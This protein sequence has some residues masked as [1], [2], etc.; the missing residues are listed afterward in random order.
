MALADSTIS[1]EILLEK[2]FLYASRN[3]AEFPGLK[4]SAT[5]SYIEHQAQG[6]VATMR[7]WCAAGRIPTNERTETVE[8]PDGVWQMFKHRHLPYW[9]RKRFPVRMKTERFTITTNH[10]FVC[11]HIVMGKQEKHIKFML[12][13]NPDAYRWMKDV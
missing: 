6:L 12:T 11:P 8:Y 10:Y 9:F 2:V 4:E 1:R 13:G 3:F 7:A 5:V